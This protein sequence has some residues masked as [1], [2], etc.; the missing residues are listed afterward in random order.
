[1]AKQIL[2]E[3]EARGKLKSGVDK[4]ANAVKVT[5]GSKGR[6]VVLGQSFGAPEVC[7]DGVTIAKEIELP[8]KVENMGA[9]IVKQVAEKTNDVAGDGTTTSIV[10][11]QAI[12]SEGLKNVAAGANPLALK[13]GIDKGVKAVVKG[14]KKM[15]IPISQKEKI[16]QVAT[17]AALNRQIGEMIAEVI[18]EVGKDGVV[19]VEESKRLGLEKEVVKGLQ[20]DNGYNSPCMV[21]DTERM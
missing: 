21:T 15:A 6:Y 18:S 13:K 3:E 12:V 17:V 9:E 5:L 11:T 4:L 1:M 7:D 19:T 16:A 20:F 10:L 14:I 8:D 2:F